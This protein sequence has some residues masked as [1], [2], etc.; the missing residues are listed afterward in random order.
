MVIIMHCPECESESFVKNGFNQIDKQIYRCK[1]CGR[2][3]VLDPAKGPV[4]E[5][6]K[7]LIDRLLLERISLAGIS[8]SVGVSESWLQN[9]VNQKYAGVPRQILVKKKRLGV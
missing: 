6:K 2:Q 5:E 1:E 7:S 9:Y 3:F 8:R 4:S